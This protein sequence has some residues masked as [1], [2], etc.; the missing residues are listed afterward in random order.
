MN[1]HVNNARYLEWV[2]NEVPMERL[3]SRDLKI[4]EA[5]FLS[6]VKADD[7]LEILIQNPVIQNDEFQGFIQR[8]PGYQ[9]VFAARLILS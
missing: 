6:E 4:I 3:L 5:N 9:P 8:I 7:E 2:I 1:L